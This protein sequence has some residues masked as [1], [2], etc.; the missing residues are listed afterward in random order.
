MS[1]AIQL[2]SGALKLVGRPD[3]QTPATGYARTRTMQVGVA[4]LT[5]L[6]HTRAPQASTLC[7]APQVALLGMGKMGGAMALRLREQGHAVTVWNR[8][9][10][11]ADAVKAE[12]LPGECTVSETAAEAVASTAPGAMILLILSDTAACLELVAALGAALVLSLIHI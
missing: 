4:P 11:K 6:G 3:L 1:V 12:A 9:R 10:A 5:T 2:S 7:M 8:S